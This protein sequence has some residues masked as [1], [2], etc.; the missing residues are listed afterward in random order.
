MCIDLFG[1]SAKTTKRVLTIIAAFSVLFASAQKGGSSD[2][3]F[4]FDSVFDRYGQET[5]MVALE[6]KVTYSF[7]RAKYGHD[8]IEVLEK[9]E[10]KFCAL[11]D[12]YSFNYVTF[13]DSKSHVALAKKSK[14]NRSNPK[15]L[16]G[17]FISDYEGQGVF[18][19]D[20][21]LCHFDLDFNNT[22]DTR[23]VRVEKKYHDAKFL[24]SVYF[25]KS[26]PSEYREIKFVIPPWL[27]LELI[28]M[29]FD[30][31]QIEK[32]DKKVGGNRVV[33]YKAR[34]IDNTINEE[35][36]PGPTYYEPHIVLVF[37]GYRPLGQSGT[38]PVLG[39]AADL[40]K[41]YKGLV[42]EEEITDEMK[43]RVRE[44][45]A[46]KSSDEEKIKAVFYWVQ[47]NIRYIAFEDGIMGF[48]PE[49]AKAV[50]MQKYG[51]CKGMA[52]LIKTLLREIGLDARLTWIGTNRK[53]PAYNYSIPNLAVDN[54]MICTVI[55]NGERYF[56]DGTEK[57][58]GLGDYAARIQGRQVL[59][60]DGENY[61]IDTVP[62]T[63]SSRN[64]TNYKRNLRIEGDELV[65]SCD[66][67]LNG[68]EKTAMLNMFAYVGPTL[69]KELINIYLTTDDKDVVITD[70]RTPSS[71]DRENNLRFQF[72]FEGK[73]MFLEFDSELYINLEFDRDYAVGADLSGRRTD[74]QL[75][76]QFNVNNHT[77]LE[78]PTGY[79]V[80]H[81]PANFEID[82]KWF[83]FSLTYTEKDG[84]IYYVKK[85]IAKQ[86]VFPKEMLEQW[87]DAVRQLRDS[88]K[89]HVV[90]IKV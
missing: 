90:L 64:E 6:S 11:K 47:D 19:S 60:E 62:Q 56:L 29:N 57:F 82:N 25:R 42:E 88:Y 5:E 36:S 13:F 50:F 7:V 74:L 66:F 15:L 52:N 20:L 1:L 84:K 51:D 18:Y 2:D 31:I 22:Y 48:K 81:L 70:L 38:W 63:G 4:I 45:T 8:R 55:L 80:K 9:Y 49:A 86:R 78:I 79:K 85:L 87:D 14:I 89:N 58:I 26:Y 77:E 35:G 73:N 30:E 10:E 72:E 27:D 68:E 44:L 69:K 46:A 40:Y 39:S 12:N 23:S 43:E 16:S 33:T 37:K 67:A 41:W 75:P 53:S 17:A 21:R 28:E 59:I 61:I 34:Q 65:G 54:H 83:S 32:E 71:I 24:T 76:Y 3:G